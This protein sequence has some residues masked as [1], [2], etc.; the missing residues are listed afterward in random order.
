MKL[1]VIVVSAQ[2]KSRDV[3]LVLRLEIPKLD[4]GVAALISIPALWAKG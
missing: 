1:M 4:V 3:L 2:A